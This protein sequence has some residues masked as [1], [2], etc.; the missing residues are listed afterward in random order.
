[1]KIISPS[2]KRAETVKTHLILSNIEYAVHEFE[3]QEYRDAGHSVI[4]LPDSTRGNIPNLRNW[5]I[6]KY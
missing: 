5:L 1:M 4:E 6:E 3:A 2:Y